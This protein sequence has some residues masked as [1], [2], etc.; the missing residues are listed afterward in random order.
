ML[1][2]KNVNKRRLERER[3]RDNVIAMRLKFDFI[4]RTIQSPREKALVPSYQF[5]IHESLQS[6]NTVSSKTSEASHFGERCA[7]QWWL[8]HLPTFCL[9][10]GHKMQDFSMRQ[11]QG[12][13]IDEKRCNSRYTWRHSPQS[14]TDCVYGNTRGSDCGNIKRDGK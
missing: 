2:K 5:L 11:E 3:E 1:L 9:C 10:H 7:H 12:T 4:H 8:Q 6:H 14:T 13:I